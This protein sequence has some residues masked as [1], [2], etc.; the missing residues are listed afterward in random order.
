MCFCLMIMHPKMEF[1]P[2]LEALSLFDANLYLKE[3]MAGWRKQR[4][5]H[6]C[7]RHFLVQYQLTQVIYPGLRPLTQ[8]SVYWFTSLFIH[9]HS[10]GVSILSDQDSTMYFTRSTYLQAQLVGVVVVSYP[11]LNVHT[12]GEDTRQRRSEPWDFNYV[13]TSVSVRPRDSQI[14]DIHRSLYRDGIITLVDL[15][16]DKLSKISFYSMN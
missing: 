11:Y 1:Q 6:G 3:N 16:G 13:V 10:F 5:F 15:M 14:R 2:W 7:M 9:F 8:G 4:Q 12:S